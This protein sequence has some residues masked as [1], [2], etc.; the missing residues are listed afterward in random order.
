MKKRKS[1]VSD[2]V[3]LLTFIQPRD[4]IARERGERGLP[5]LPSHKTHPLNLPYTHILNKFGEAKN[6]NVH[7]LRVMLKKHEQIDSRKSFKMR[8]NQNIQ[9]EAKY[10]NPYAT[11]SW[12]N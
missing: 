10:Y 1:L 7:K 2:A 5:F 6:K 3:N 8:C 9:N 4:A 11:K 12:M